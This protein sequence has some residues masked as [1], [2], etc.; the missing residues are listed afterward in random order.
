MVAQEV[1][2]EQIPRKFH[3]MESL[4]FKSTNVTPCVQ[5]PFFTFGAWSSTLVAIYG[6][7]VSFDPSAQLIIWGH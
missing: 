2:R 3:V 4:K 1:L 6:V 5:S 7:L